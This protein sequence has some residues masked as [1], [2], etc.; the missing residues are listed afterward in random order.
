MGGA[1]P[2]SVS[3]LAKQRQRGEMGTLGSGN[4]YLEVQ[5]VDRIHD[6]QAAT[7]YGLRKRRGRTRTW[8]WSPRPRRRRAWRAGWSSCVPRSA[9]RGEQSPPEQ[10]TSPPTAV[11]G[12]MAREEGDTMDKG[13][14]HLIVGNDKRKLRTLLDHII[15]GSGWPVAGIRGVPVS[16]VAHGP[17]TGYLLQD[18]GSGEEALAASM[19]FSGPPM[20][21]KFGEDTAAIDYIVGACR[22]QLLEPRLVIID[23]IGPIE[24]TPTPS[25]CGPTA[26]PPHM[27][28]PWSAT[29][30]THP[31]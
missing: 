16:D 11:F 20:V 19:D 17:H 15:A 9:S 30:R 3:D 26:T 8:T 27:Q 10:K 25:G 6:A 1:H 7:A 23:E 22:R 24:G 21:E 2:E 29:C 28:P 31:A 13:K 18:L 4:H 14:K 12:V 5:V